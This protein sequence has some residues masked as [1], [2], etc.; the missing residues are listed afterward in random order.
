MNTSMTF[1]SIGVSFGL[2][3][4]AGL[5]FIFFTEQIIDYLGYIVGFCIILAGLVNIISYFRTNLTDNLSFG[6]AI[7]AI[8]ISIGLYF[9]IVPD[10]IFN[11]ASLFFGFYVIVNGIMGLQFA[12]NAFRLGNARWLVVL[13]CALISIILG[14]II[15]YNPFGETEMLV[16]WIGGF[17][18][19]TA[20]FNGLSLFLLKR[21]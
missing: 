8:L 10:S 1:R 2:T 15:L 14:G 4:I 7:G 12:L 17:M 9:I 3:I 16:R 11:I 18:I 21:S 20:L 19:A 5:L 13:I 6:F